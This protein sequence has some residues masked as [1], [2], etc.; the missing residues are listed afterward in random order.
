MQLSRARCLRCLVL[1]RSRTSIAY[2]A[3]ERE[4]V[5]GGEEGESLCLSWTG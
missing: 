3:R 1:Q 4:E 2:G 5:E